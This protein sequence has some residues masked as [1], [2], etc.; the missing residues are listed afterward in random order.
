MDNRLWLW[1][2]SAAANFA[3]TPDARGQTIE[4][5]IQNAF[6]RE[7]FAQADESNTIVH[8][9]VDLEDGRVFNAQLSSID[10]IGRV[11]VMQD[12]ST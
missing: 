11:A 3:I 1:S 4:S 2:D 7:L 6:V 12:I 8:T 5:H 10:H 9:E